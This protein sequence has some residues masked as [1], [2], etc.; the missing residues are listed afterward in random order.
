MIP[1]AELG[2]PVV[3]ADGMGRAFPETQMTSF[4]IGGQ[5]TSPTG[6][7]DASGTVLVVTNAPSRLQLEHTMRAA[8]IAMGCTAMMA[9]APMSG[10]FV[11]ANGINHSVGV[12]DPCAWR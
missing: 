7:A 2:L 1:A 3:D 9:T 10:T 6:L 12:G 8:T 4:F 11:K 5:P